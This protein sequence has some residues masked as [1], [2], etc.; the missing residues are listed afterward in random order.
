MRVFRDTD[1]L[2]RW[3]YAI[4]EQ[5]ICKVSDAQRAMAGASATD[6]SADGALSV[7]DQHGQSAMIRS[8]INGLPPLVR[9]YAIAMFSWG[10]ERNVALTTLDEYMSRETTVANIKMRKGLVRRYTDLGRKNRPT[11]EEIARRV[12]V[13]ERTVRRHEADIIDVMDKLRFQFYWH[14]DG[15][16]AAAGLIQ[17]QNA[18]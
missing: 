1:A 4:A 5:P 3:A 16:F 7:H 13:H 6:K 11:H 17:S 8:H 18:A 2:L 12:G 9:A 15:H 10:D 14:L